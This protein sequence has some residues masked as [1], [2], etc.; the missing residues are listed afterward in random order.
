MNFRLLLIALLFSGCYAGEVERDLNR[1]PFF[2]LAGYIDAQVDSLTALRPT[3]EKTVVLNGT[4][5]TKQLTDLNFAT[6]LRL[7]READINKPAWLDKYSVAT[8]ERGGSR[9]RIYTATDSSLQTRLLEVVTGPE[10]QPERIL[11]ERR[12]GTVLSDGNHRLVYSPASG[13]EIHTEQT[14]RFGDDLDAT[15]TVRWV[16][17]K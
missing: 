4:E 11:I 15:I 16:Q 17:K 2:D 5:E 1:E 14:N 3:V 7:F 10:D 8:E 6:D 13:Y 12:T 9:A